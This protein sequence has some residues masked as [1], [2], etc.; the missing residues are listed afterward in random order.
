MVFGVSCLP[1]CLST[2]KAGCGA[3]ALGLGVRSGKDQAVL[4]DVLLAQCSM[5]LRSR[6]DRDPSSP[7]TTGAHR[8]PAVWIPE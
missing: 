3:A 4:A 5:P 7:V 6:W 2:P 8:T 1:P